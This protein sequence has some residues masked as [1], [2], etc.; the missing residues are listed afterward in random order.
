MARILVVTDEVMGEVLAGPALRACAI[1]ETL[2][3]DH[4]VAVRSTAGIDVAPVAGATGGFVG[5]IDF[6]NGAALDKDALED[7][8]RWADIIVFG[9]YLLVRFPWLRRSNTIMVADLYD[10]FHLE[11]LAGFGASVINQPTTDDGVVEAEVLSDRIVDEGATGAPFQAADPDHPGDHHQAQTDPGQDPKGDAAEEATAKDDAAADDPPG[12]GGQDAV[13]LHRLDTTLDALSDQMGR[14]DFMMCASE[15]QR[16]FWLGHLGAVGRLNPVAQAQDPTFR[17]MID[18]CP[19]GLGEPPVRSGTGLRGHRDGPFAAIGN[20]DPVVL[21]GGGVYDWLDVHTTIDAIAQLQ[22]EITGLRLVFLGGPHP[23]H[24]ESAALRD[25]RRY[26]RDADLG[27]SVLFNDA[28]VPFGERHNYLM[29]ASVGITTHHEHL[30]TRFAFRTRVLDY[31]WCGLPMVLSGGDELGDAVHRAG[32]GEVCAPGDVDAVASGLA[33]LLTDTDAHQQAASAA[34]ALSETYRWSRAL[35]PL[36]D[37][38]RDPMPAPDLADEQI[39]AVVAR[40]SRLPGTAV[41]PLAGVGRDAV[42]AARVIRN[43]GPSDLLR[44]AKGRRK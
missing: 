28:W 34:R 38:C 13:E 25:A 33:H 29:D 2:S 26:A 27:D 19:F 4:E 22:A 17:K 44:R 12:S 3:V 39:A 5:A 6:G 21:W 8:D 9:G 36:V 31:L 11:V 35:A 42:R 20:H 10:P 14:A 37:F 30:E 41:A 23:T 16:D 43:V 1:A 7:L 40:R 15:R 32:A 24:G 18:V